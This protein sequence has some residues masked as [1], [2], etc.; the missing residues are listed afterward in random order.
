MLFHEIYGRYY[1]TVAA[2]LQKAAEGSLSERD[3]T[4]LVQQKAF[5][6]SMLTIP[7]ALKDGTWPL[8]TPT[9]TTPLRHAPTMP[10]T[11]LQ[12]RW[13]KSLL[14]D[15][16]IRL[17]C[18]DTAG[19]EEVEPLY[20][21]DTFVYFDRYADGD[22]YED[23]EYITHFHTILTALQQKRR[24]WVE[25]EGAGGRMNQWVCLPHRL[26]YSPKDDKFR[27]VVQRA[28]GVAAVNIARI[29]VC[30]LA[31]PYEEREFLPLAEEQRTLELELINERNA[32]ERVMLHF[33][34]L[35]K[36]T[37]C[38]DELHYRLTLHYDRR[39]ETEL[40]IRVLSFGPVLKVLA[41]ESFRRQVIERLQKQQALCTAE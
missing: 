38:I 19:L 41:P 6:E 37:R 17:F 34:H 4:E 22:P 14:N 40:L 33:S 21:P 12:K 25:F 35:Q 23:A 36:E 24:L 8:L 9:L 11:A 1:H 20:S 16:R 39:D 15:P 29:A 28:K 32:L 5:S 10:L 30:R 13:L 2:I 7:A 3:I 18:P 26:E 27:L 31:N